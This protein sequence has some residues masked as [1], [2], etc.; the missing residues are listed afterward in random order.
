MSLSASHEISRANYPNLMGKRILVVDDEPVVA[1]DYWYQL[2][3][4]G[5]T[6]AGFLPSNQAAMNFLEAHRVDAVIV[7]HCLRD[8]TS[9]PV[10]A[11]LVAH[12]VPFVMVS[13]W[14]EKVMRTRALMP[15]LEKP[16]VPGDLWK[17][18]SEIVH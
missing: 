8:G 6:P 2:L 12:H 18:L 11:W 14:V 13:G 10:V 16:A 3:E 9:E 1:V 5:A 17:A 4:V 15:I 7:D